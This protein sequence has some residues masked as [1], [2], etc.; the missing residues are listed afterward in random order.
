MRTVEQ[1][2][3]EFSLERDDLL[4]E[5]GLHD[6]QPIGGA[7]EVQLLG[8]RHE[9]LE[10]PELQRPRRVRQAGG[11]GWPCASTS[12]ATRRIVVRN[13]RTSADLLSRRQ[14]AAS[15]ISGVGR[16]SGR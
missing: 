8:N 5:R 14:Q 12:G 13:A 10:V 9:V 2:A 16:V 15:S 1:V 11:G 6:M 4:A 3:V 7:A